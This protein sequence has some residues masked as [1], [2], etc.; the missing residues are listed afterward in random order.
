V[1]E[2]APTH[3]RV[4]GARYQDLLEATAGYQRTGIPLVALNGISFAPAGPVD[5]LGIYYFIPKLSQILGWTVFRA[6]DVFYL[7]I[8]CLSFILGSLGLYLWA[9]SQ[10]VKWLSLA[11]LLVLTA[12]SYHAGDVYIFSM[13]ASVVAVA[14][15]LYVLREHTEKPWLP[16][17]FL[18]VGLLLGLAHLVRSHSGTPALLFTTCLLLLGFPHGFK[19]NALLLGVLLV[20]FLLPQLWLRSMVHK[21][22]NFL[23][24]HCS[25]YHAFTSHHVFWH[26]IYVGFG[27]LSNDYVAAYNDMIAYV[28]VQS[29]APGTVFGSQEYERILR[30]QVFQLIRQHPGFALLTLT[31]KAGVMLFIFLAACNVGILAAFK[32]PKPW[33]L[34]LAFWS[35]IGFSSLPGLLVVPSSSGYTLGL[36]TLATLYAIVSIDFARARQGHSRKLRQVSSVIPVAVR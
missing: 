31:A 35:A 12:W 18:S 2:S 24:E 22:D 34:E 23:T 19:R 33:P 15:V 3:V 27:F 32:F 30:G 7:S 11:W 28:K 1:L 4:M 8:L 16:A 9:G 21:R 20:G 10:F 6:I 29:L 5:D 14:W 36:V 13:F 25:N 26:S 17:L